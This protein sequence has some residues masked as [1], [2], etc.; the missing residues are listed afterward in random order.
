MNSLPNDIPTR[1]ASDETGASL[2]ARHRNYRAAKV[3]QGLLVLVS[4][5]LPVIRGLIGPWR[6]PEIRPYLALGQ[7][8]LLVMETGLFDRIQKDRLEARRQAAGAV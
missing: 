6:V 2:R 1:Q 8:D 3:T 5:L 7:P 4:I